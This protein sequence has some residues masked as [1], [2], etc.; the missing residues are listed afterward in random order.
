MG[1]NSLPKTVTRQR[2]GCYLNPSP[3]A[4]ESSML[5]TRLPSH[6]LGV[7]DHLNKG[8]SHPTPIEIPSNFFRILFT[9]MGSFFDRVIR[10]IIW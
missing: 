2:R 3:S 6:R 10:E 8:A 5:T 4:P 1:V 7:Q 9:Q